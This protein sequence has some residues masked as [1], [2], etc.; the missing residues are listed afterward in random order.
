MS[1]AIELDNHKKKKNKGLRTV[2]Q[3]SSYS[4]N[5]PQ[6]QQTGFSISC[7]VNFLWV[8]LYESEMVSHLT[9]KF[10]VRMG[11][12]FDSNYIFAKYVISCCCLFIGLSSHSCSLR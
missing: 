1:E 2:K 9:S 11:P 7:T 12:K 3:G 5:Q 4:M 8:C 10:Q 6:H